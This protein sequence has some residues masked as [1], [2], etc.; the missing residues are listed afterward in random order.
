MPTTFGLG[1]P[2]LTALWQNL[3]GVVTLHLC[4]L[5]DWA[6]M[7]LNGAMWWKRWL[8]T[9]SVR[10]ATTQELLRVCRE[11]RGTL[12]RWKATAT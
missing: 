10:A 2:C 4:R 9:A 5:G 11:V 8:A 6:G 7:V 3:R 12:G 1:R